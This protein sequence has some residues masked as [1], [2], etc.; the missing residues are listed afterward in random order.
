M[1]LMTAVPN[2]TG[3]VSSRGPSTSPELDV[4]VG[5]WSDYVAELRRRRHALRRL[6]S[7]RA[8]T[9][10]RPLAHSLNGPARRALLTASASA[11]TLT[12]SRRRATKSFLLR[13]LPGPRYHPARLRLQ[14]QSKDAGTR[15]A[16]RP[17]ALG[18]L[19]L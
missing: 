5:R 17:W 15:I 3:P 9:V 10:R 19:G 8:V 4:T 7:R 1:G 13:S 2:P 16:G 14:R 12:P 18:G 11:P 6:G